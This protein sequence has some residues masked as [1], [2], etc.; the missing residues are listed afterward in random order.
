MIGEASPVTT[1]SSP[2]YRPLRHLCW[3]IPCLLY[4]WAVL[5]TSDAY[6]REV[7]DFPDATEYALLADRIA[8]GRSPLI[9]VGAQLY[10][11]RYPLVFPLLLT[12]FAWIFHSDLRLFFWASA[13]FGLIAVV[14]IA[15]VGAWMLGS[16]WA[17]GLAAALWALH[18][19][20]VIA[21]TMTMSET[22]VTMMFFFALALARPLLQPRAG[23]TPDSTPAIG[24]ARALALGL[25]LGW[26][27]LA[28]SPFIY[29]V[30]AFAAMAF[31][32]AR[33]RRRWG[34]FTALVGAGLACCVADMLYRRWAFGVWGMNG[35]RFWEPAIYGDLG[36]IF[37]PAYLTTHWLSA[38]EDGNIVYYGRMLLGRTGEFYSP[39]MP[40][41]LA[42]AAVG[43]IWSLRRGRPTRP[44]V[45]LMAGWAVIGALFCGFYFF[46]TPRFLLIWMPV[47]D[48]LAAWGLMQMPFWGPLRRRRFLGTRL[49][50]WGR[51]FALF[52]IFVLARGELLRV[53][54]Y[55]HLPQHP[56]HVHGATTDRIVPLLDRVPDGAWL[57]TNYQLPIVD[58]LRPH[59][60]PTAALD[61]WRP[62]NYLM[63]G[64]VGAISEYRLRP[65]SPRESWTGWVDPLPDPWRRGPTL[66]ID[67]DRNWLL[68]PVQL[69]S[70]FDRP[71][72]LLVVDPWQVKA[73]GEQ[74]E[75][76]VRP[77]V[78]SRLRLE[79]IQSSANVTL[80][81]L[82]P[83]AGPAAAGRA[84]N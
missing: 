34:A 33:D 37:N 50:T 38:T 8:H 84:S 7:M 15:R 74:F 66:L 29:W 39:Y 83:A 45:A 36:R 16:R 65:H 2:S 28:K 11:S 19:Q 13:V 6:G 61:T 49:S 30:A 60:G 53:R 21:S 82:E 31:F 35:Y 75:Q 54:G 70:L 20:T 81:R 80:Y 47:A 23:E 57:L 12:P 56:G 64:H 22:A 55:L 46:P 71:A 48:L 63:S 24:V 77:L 9:P 72:F 1:H 43:A 44:V 10:P 58:A 27:T 73:T 78:E 4:L 76:V 18:P 62:D 67:A 41:C 3:L 68:D 26:L 5:P 40:V 42:L 52:A 79:P 25:V 69:A 59:P 14:S 51:G 32:D 17:G